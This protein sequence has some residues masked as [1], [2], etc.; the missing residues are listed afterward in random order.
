MKSIQ[1]SYLLVFSNDHHIKINFHITAL[2]SEE[3]HALPKV[4]CSY[5]KS[6]HFEECYIV[7]ID[8]HVRYAG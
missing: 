4:L 3:T 1:K 5:F 7:R 8:F 6:R 2:G